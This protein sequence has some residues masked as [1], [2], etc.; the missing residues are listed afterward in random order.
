MAS[1]IAR[2]A[3]L[4]RVL[5]AEV[6]QQAKECRTFPDLASWN[7][8]HGVLLTANDAERLLA[9]ITPPSRPKRVACPTCEGRGT[10]AKPFDANCPAAWAHHLVRSPE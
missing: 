8:E 2:Q 4:D 1:E 10:M 5:V 7:D 9:M 3:K 6:R